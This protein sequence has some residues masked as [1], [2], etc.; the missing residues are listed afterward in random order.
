MPLTNIGPESAKIVMSQEIVSIVTSKA[1]D[2]VRIGVRKWVVISFNA[3]SN[4][5]SGM[6]SFLRRGIARQNTIAGTKKPTK[7]LTH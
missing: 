3:M 4:S 7:G 2:S 6:R 1:A 5:T